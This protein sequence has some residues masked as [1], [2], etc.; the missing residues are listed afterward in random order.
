LQQ[1]QDSEDAFQAVF[2]LLAQRLHSVR[3]HDSLA[4]WLHG[5]ARR[6]ALKA[7][8]R[9]ATRVRHEQESSVHR[10]LPRDEVTW[11][12][13]RSV[14]DLG[15]C[16]ITL[17]RRLEDARTT[18]A[19]RLGRH[20]VWPTALSAVLLSDGIGSAAPAHALIGCTVEAAARVA[21]GQAP[22]LLVSARVL[23]LMQG[24]LPVMPLDKLGVLLVLVL[25]VGS[26]FTAAGLSAYYAP[27][28]P[29][30]VPRKDKAPPAMGKQ[31]K[32]ADKLPGQWLL[33]LP[34]GFQYQVVIRQVGEK[35][36]SLEKAVRFS[37]VYE[38][39]DGQLVLVKPARPG[40]SAYAW[41]VR[42][43]EWTLVAQPP[44]AKTGSNYLGAIL[45]RRQRQ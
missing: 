15:W 45:T 18:L 10:T 42:G 44:V 16:K 12:E 36:Y 3:K 1:E 43:D 41:K 7:K 4:S 13:L 23:A 11:K 6:V 39:R 8:A 28:P 27:A 35:R 9:A 19:Q 20:G 25:T 40:E 24:V 26:F 34:A 17:R 31:G 33:K 22:T 5:V 38:L 37:G 2:L 30:P 14:L 29:P 32:P 21:A